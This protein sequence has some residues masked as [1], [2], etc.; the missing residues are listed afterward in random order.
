[1]T[2]AK[3]NDSEKSRLDLIPY[4][5][6]EELGHVLGHGAAKYGEYNWKSGG[7]LE[8]K[9]S[10]AACLRHL[11]EWSTGQNIDAD[12]GRSHLIHAMANL[13]FL[14]HYSLNKIEFPKDFRQPEEKPFLTDQWGPTLTNTIKCQCA[15]CVRK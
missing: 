5:V 2:E 3:K 8:W 1:M 9:R 14:A 4:G 10:Y 15:S 7:G 11:G 6:L 12:S 13:M